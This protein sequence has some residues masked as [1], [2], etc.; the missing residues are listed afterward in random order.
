MNAKLFEI[1]VCVYSR[2]PASLLCFSF[3]KNLSI[4][5]NRKIGLQLDNSSLESCLWIR[6]T[7]AFFK[8]VGNIPGEKDK[9]DIVAK[10]LH[11]W[12]WTR[13]KISVGI[14]L[15][16]QNLLILK[17]EIILEISSLFVA[18]MTK[19]V[20]FCWEKTSKGFVRKFDLWLSNW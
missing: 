13:W 15:G 1:R 18:A 8:I 7:L 3:S 11:I 16:P 17:D 14:L 19:V 5:D 9:L 12:Y 6:I 20:V 4:L 10:C 2:N